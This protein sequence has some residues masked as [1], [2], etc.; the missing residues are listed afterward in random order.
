ML[1]H[2][3]SNLK[4]IPV[5]KTVVFYSPIEGDDVLVR[6][7]IISEGS[8]FF[9]SLLHAYSKDYATMSRKDRMKFVHR[10]KASY[11]GR[12]DKENWENM[13]NGILAMEPFK[14]N[15][16]NIITNFYNFLSTTNPV[17]GKSTRRV[18][19]NLSKTSAINLQV[20]NILMDLLP[21]D[22]CLD[23]H[24]IPTA[25][26]QL[27]IQSYTKVL[28]SES[29]SYI[30]ATKILDSIDPKKAQFIKETLTTF[31]TIVTKEARDSAFKEYISN[32]NKVMLDID[33]SVIDFIT[34]RLNRDIYFIDGSTRLPCYPHDFNKKRKAIIVLS[35]DNGKHYEVV[36]RLLPGNRIQR[37]FDSSDHLIQKIFLLNNNPQEAI[38]K[39]PEL[40][41]YIQENNSPKST[42]SQEDSED[43]E[44]SDSYYDDSYS[45]SSSDGSMSE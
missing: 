30:N 44:D 14:N 22:D 9:H 24:I 11:I 21:L 12:I 41:P 35:I 37:E 45:H 39:Y 25:N 8:C 26:Q 16:L 38:I 32:L 17:K 20:Y 18:I 40:K 43:S 34:E 7:G 36:G 23:K 3:T 31:M 1:K 4:I 29:L 10:L 2:N 42:D 27:S 6:T 15:V 28:I 5:N 19:K 13:N 33:S